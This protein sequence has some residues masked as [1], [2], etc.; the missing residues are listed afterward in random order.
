MLQAPAV[1]QTLARFAVQTR[2]EDVPEAARHE[3]K[4]GC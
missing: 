3:A 2:W 1:T 4:R